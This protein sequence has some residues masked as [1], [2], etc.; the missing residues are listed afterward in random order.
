M[1]IYLRKVASEGINHHVEHYMFVP[2]SRVHAPVKRA[3]ACCQ[4]TDLDNGWSERKA[5]YAY[6][7]TCT[8]S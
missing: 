1:N 6:K 4:T 5:P 8:R 2:A 7:E 3:P